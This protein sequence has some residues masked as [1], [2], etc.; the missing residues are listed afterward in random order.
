[1]EGGDLTDVDRDEDGVETR[2]EPDHQPSHQQH[3]HSSVV[4]CSVEI[5][6][7]EFIVMLR[8]LSY[9]IKNQ[10]NRTFPWMESLILMP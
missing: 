8:Q 4:H 6:S 10:L 7:E 3:L 2:S 1:M 9:A 5:I